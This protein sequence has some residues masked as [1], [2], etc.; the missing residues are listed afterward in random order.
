MVVNPLC[1]ARGAS[2]ILEKPAVVQ[3]T[4]TSSSHLEL[5]TIDDD[6]SSLG[7]CTTGV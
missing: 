1:K 2:A 4:T 3:Q 7:W 5:F 6:V